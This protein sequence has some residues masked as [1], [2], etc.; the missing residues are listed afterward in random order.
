MQRNTATHANIQLLYDT[1][2]SLLEVY[3][4]I[5]SLH[6]TKILTH[7]CLLQHYSK[8]KMETAERAVIR[9]TEKENVVYIHSGSLLSDKKVSYRKINQLIYEK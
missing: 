4:K 3:L 1:A 9:R 5:L 8:A 6:T 2:I 7:L